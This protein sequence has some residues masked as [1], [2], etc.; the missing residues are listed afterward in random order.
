[1]KPSVLITGLVCLAVMECVAL[2]NGVN[3]T[4]LTFV[5]GVFA[6]VMGLSVDRPKV[7]KW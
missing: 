4:L 3:G 1:M 6:G 7:F 2:S 5:V